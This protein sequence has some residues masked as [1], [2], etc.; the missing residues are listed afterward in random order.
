MLMRMDMVDLEAV[1]TTIGHSRIRIRKPSP[2]KRNKR[3]RG[4]SEHC[5]S[6][7]HDAP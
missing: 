3:Y 6:L 4:S 2:L 7:C 1:K 5:S